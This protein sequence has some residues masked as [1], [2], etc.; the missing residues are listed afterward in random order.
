VTARAAIVALIALV[1]S[2]SAA[3]AVPPAQPCPYVSTG[4]TQ[5]YSSG[6]ISSVSYS[7]DTQML[8]VVFGQTTVSAFSNVPVSVMQAF[9]ATQTPIS[10]YNSAVVHSYHAMLL[11]Q[12]TNCPFFNDNG[13]Q[14]LWSD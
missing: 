14:P 5:S 4:W 8:F 9:S 12:P 2:A 11:A 1:A 6:S 7:T 10:V 3:D 13:T